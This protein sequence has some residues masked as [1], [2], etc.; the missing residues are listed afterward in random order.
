MEVGNGL[1][2][3]RSGALD[4]SKVADP[5]YSSECDLFYGDFAS[6]YS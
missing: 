4:P 1:E 6:V 5:V 2:R 3:T